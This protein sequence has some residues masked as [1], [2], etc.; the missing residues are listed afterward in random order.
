MVGAQTLLLP[1]FSQTLLF[2][3]VSALLIP[4]KQPTS[5]PL[6]QSLSS[7]TVL[8]GITN[9]VPSEATAVYLFEKFWTPNI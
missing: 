8:V 1:P 9:S 3:T 7:F 2:A 5:L 4:D 6:S